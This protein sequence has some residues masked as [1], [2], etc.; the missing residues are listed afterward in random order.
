[1]IA[2]L[3]QLRARARGSPAMIRGGQV[4]VIWWRVASKRWRLAAN[5]I[6]TPL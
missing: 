6:T 1:M 4:R 2:F 3:D 5:K